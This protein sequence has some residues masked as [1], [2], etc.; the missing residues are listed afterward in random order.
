MEKRML[1]LSLALPMALA[2]TAAGADTLGVWIGANYW[3]FDISGTARYKSKSSADDID[4]ND[5]LGYDDD[6][7]TTFYAIFEH[8]APLIPNVKVV[9]TNID[10][11]ANGSLSKDF[12][13]GD[14]DFTINEDVRSE[15]QLDQID[16]ALYWRILDNAANL[17]IGINAKYI[18]IDATITGAI[19]G[20]DTADVS[21]LVPMLYAGVGIDLPL[22]GVGVSA[23][24]A[25]IGYDGSNFY[26]FTVRATYD[27]P[28]FLGIEAGYRKLKLDLDNFD[29]SYADVEFG[30]P[31]LG[32]YVHF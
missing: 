15:V 13:W 6:T 17:D 3:D 10:S 2:T 32:A 7:L 26:D 11:D 27:S 20:S 29:D 18:D 12:T 25:Y 23:N 24:G 19:S 16:V 1:A 28:W 30:G 4:V 8:P 22:T 31:Y 5:D 9:S 14:I 21:G